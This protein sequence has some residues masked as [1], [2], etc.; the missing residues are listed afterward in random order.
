MTTDVPP[1][2]PLCFG[3]F[4]L[5]LAAARLS[6]DGQ[7]LALRPKAFE[8]LATLAGRPDELHTKDSLLDTVWG[9]RFISEGV[10]KSVV[11]EL[12]AVLDHAPEDP[13]Q[14]SWI[15][16]VPR[17]G[18]R[19]AGA[20]RT[21]DLADS[22]NGV[23]LATR[24][25]APL[26][27]D[28]VSGRGSEPLTTTIGREVELAA[29]THLML[30][31]RLLTVAG[32]SG[33][34]K[35]RLAQALAAG[36][37]SAWSGGVWFVELAPLAAESTDVATLY[38]MLAQTLQLGAAAALDAA[39]LG[40]ALQ[41]L[42]LLLV[43]DNAEHLLDLLT[44]LVTAL[45]AQAPALRIVVTSQEPLAV[46]GEQVFRLAP[47]ALPAVADDGDAQRLMASGAVRLFVER[48]AARLPGFVLAPQQ[49]QGIAD[50]C[51]ALDG[52]PLALELAA[53][54]VPV[55]GV[56]GIANMLLGDDS[57][58][59]LDLLRQGPRTAAPRQRT[60]RDALQWSHDLLD[61]TQRRV[62]RRLGVFHGGFSLVAAQ[63]VCADRAL[64]AWGVLDAVQALV[65]KSLVVAQP[66][67]AG[68]MRFT[69]LESLRAFALER[70]HGAAETAVTRRRHLSATREAWAAADAQALSRPALPW[71]ACHLP[72][73]D[74]L[75]AALRF[76]ISGAADPSLADDAVALV[77]GSGMFWH[78]A[79]LVSEGAAACEAVRPYTTGPA[80]PAS[81][82]SCRGWALTVAILTVYG[83]AYPHL[84]TVAS[85]ERLAVELEQ[86]A[87]PARA[88]FALYLASRLH[89]RSQA[90]NAACA[91]VARMQMLEQ[92]GWS[93]LLTRYGKAAVA[94]EQRLAG[95]SEGYRSFCR[96]DLALCRR[97]GAT[98]ESWTAAQGLMLAEQDM[99]NA[100]T[101]LTVG[102]EAV[103]EV[104]RA[105][106]SREQAALLILW[107]T[108]L[109]E[110]G[111]TAGARS[112]L[113]EVLPALHSRGTPW[114]AYA[115][116]A[117]LAAH[118]G[119]PEVAAR[120][121]GWHDAALARQVST[122]PG[123][124]VTRSLI[125]LGQ[126]LRRELGL[127]AFAH[128]H[129][130]GASLGDQVGESLALAEPS[131]ARNDQ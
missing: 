76:A 1:P 87:E 96:D 7:A 55:L 36:Q 32:P 26:A 38:A 49:Q 130:Q 100:E 82:Q 62:F 101:A 75:R 31:H 93:E 88:Y 119:R 90:G 14:P 45:L 60:L 57:D 121:F 17:R 51:R 89:V 111:D 54:R 27:Q 120:L 124:Y 74:N 8:L 73:I 114:M 128:W 84:A 21:A 92:P 80:R 35:T 95:Q 30:A 23:D 66:D 68:G 110:S 42:A 61:D 109:A 129:A 69:L 9:R 19:F 15:E 67:D 4:R 20:V 12:R 59:R 25:P 3:P 108:M 117:W 123:P 64:N 103:A 112:A 99:G 33:V 81:D 91:L 13:S 47:L 122:R 126:R 86:A 107:T 52:L 50:I 34:G 115:A 58:A 11:S 131:R 28:A 63:T 72:D 97:L 104:R 78:R 5:D 48:V 79:G 70:L 40:R 113:D 18:Y 37:R 102:S 94:Y 106:R 22:A 105:G 85:T 125:T 10:I 16:T 39:A 53:A 83:D 29:L 43:L 77:G 2:P 116:L 127:D 118:E 41:P 71:L 56:H 6:R 44:P 98:L 65:D 24:L 46:A